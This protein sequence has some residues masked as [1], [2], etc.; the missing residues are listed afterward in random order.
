MA[1]HAF[2]RPVGDHE[3][4]IPPAEGPQDPL[5]I[6]AGL[7]GVDPGELQRVEGAQESV[8]SDAPEVS[9]RLEDE[10]LAHRPSRPPRGRRRSAA[11]TLGV[12]V[13]MGAVGGGVG[14]WA[15]MGAPGLPKAPHPMTAAAD[16]PRRPSPRRPRLRR[17]IP[18]RPKSSPPPSS[19]FM[20]PRLR[21]PRPRLRLRRPPCGRSRLSPPRRRKRKFPRRPRPRPPRFQR[22]SW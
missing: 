4:T 5:A 14:A 12:L 18:P 1:S 15:L 16:A 17:S 7:M 13:A 11:A 6:F 3:G 10:L 9:A 8:P 19:K 21:R 2:K 22:R 20:R